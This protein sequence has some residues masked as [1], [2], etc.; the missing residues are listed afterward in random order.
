MVFGVFPFVEFVSGGQAG[1][2]TRPTHLK[3]H[4]EFVEASNCSMLGLEVADSS[5]AEVILVVVIDP[6]F[7]GI[8]NMRK[9]IW[10]SSCRMPCKD[11]V[12]PVIVELDCCG[13]NLD[14]TC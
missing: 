5:D 3:S 9:V 11:L 7:A 12:L 6:A 8:F 13:V 10:E 2:F 14:R 1:L 4:V